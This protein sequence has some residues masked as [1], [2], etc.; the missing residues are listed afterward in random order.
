MT[1]GSQWARVIVGKTQ[2]DEHV[3]GDLELL[4]ESIWPPGGIYAHLHKPDGSRRGSVARVE[5]SLFCHMCFRLFE[6]LKV[7]GRTWSSPKTVDGET[8]EPIGDH[9]VIRADGAIT[10]ADERP[11][12]RA[13]KPSMIR[14]TAAI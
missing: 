14:M 9:S 11:L 7:E 12:G 8:T 6:L 2:R 4:F 13:S 1:F 5:R 10:Y 3:V